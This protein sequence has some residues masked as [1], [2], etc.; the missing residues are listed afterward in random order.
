MID[1]FLIV[2]VIDRCFISVVSPCVLLSQTS[3]ASILRWKIYPEREAATDLQVLT[4]PSLYLPP[5]A[6]PYLFHLS[7][8]SLHPPLLPLLPIIIFFISLLRPFLCI[9]SNMPSFP[10]LTPILYP[11]AFPRPSPS[12]PASR[13]ARRAPCL[14]ETLYLRHKTYKSGITKRHNARVRELSVKCK[15]ATFQSRC[16]RRAQ[17]G[18]VDESLKTCWRC[19]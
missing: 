17:L 1:L 10:V 8:I 13:G 6:L 14:L 12:S 11:A 19:K 9:H 18:E 2:C 3:A 7:F 15:T 4:C 16:L 5:S